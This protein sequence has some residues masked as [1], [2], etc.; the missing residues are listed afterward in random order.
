VG[1]SLLDPA[2]RQLVRATSVVRVG[3]DARLLACLFADMILLVRED[4]DVKTGRQYR[5][6]ARVRGIRTRD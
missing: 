4:K 6:Y 1:K 5:F 2:A 3:P